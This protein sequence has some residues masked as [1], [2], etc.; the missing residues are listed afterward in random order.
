MKLFTLIEVTWVDSDHGSGWQLTTDYLP[1]TR[2]T[3]C[4]SIG[5]FLRETAA[6]L[7]IVQSHSNEGT[8]E[9]QVNGILTIPKVAIKR[10]RTI[11]P[12]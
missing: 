2:S 10:K 1:R 11:K 4:R 7:E 5:Y 8:H 12:S 6:T 3:L 9:E